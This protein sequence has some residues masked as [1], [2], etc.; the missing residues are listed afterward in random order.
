MK[1]ISIIK[2]WLWR[3]ATPAGLLMAFLL[4]G[5]CAMG[6]RFKTPVVDAPGG[7]LGQG[8]ISQ[9]VTMADLPWWD[10][11]ADD[12]LHELVRTALTNNYDLRIAIKRVEE[13]QALAAQSRAQ[14]FPQIGY[15]GDLERSRNAFGGNASPAGGQTGNPL[16]LAASA[17]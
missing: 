13:Y 12:T 16:M 11:F 1:R 4:A 8:V 3:A 6:P 2:T 5:G 10:V 14:F 15:Q 17:T 9:Q 7:F